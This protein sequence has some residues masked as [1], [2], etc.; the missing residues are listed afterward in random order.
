MENNQ[1]LELGAGVGGVGEEAIEEGA[2][3]GSLRSQDLSI[4][5]RR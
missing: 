2:D 1:G 3:S 5:Q 4:M